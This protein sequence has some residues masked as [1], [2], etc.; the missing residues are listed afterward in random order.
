MNNNLINVKKS[1]KQ[2]WYT[3]LMIYDFI[4]SF[5]IS[6]LNSIIYFKPRIKIQLMI[7]FHV[8]HLFGQSFVLV[9]NKLDQFVNIFNQN[10][11]WNDKTIIHGNNV[12]SKVA[13]PKINKI[14]SLK[15]NKHHH[16]WMN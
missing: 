8:V 15:L 10:L 4:R 3:N 9:Y 7:S 13:I 12:D 1:V 16:Q 6:L 11:D 5:K 2:T 14:K